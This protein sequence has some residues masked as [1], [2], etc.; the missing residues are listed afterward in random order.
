MNAETGDADVLRVRAAHGNTELDD[1]D[2]ETSEI[3]L[4]CRKKVM[5]NVD[6]FRNQGDRQE[7][8]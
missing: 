4:E 3:V 5:S 7:R 6:F 2:W 1:V 8:P